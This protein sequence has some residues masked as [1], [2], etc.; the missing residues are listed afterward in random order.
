MNGI[1]L[2]NEM[3][4]RS[5]A[6][7]RERAK[8][9]IMA[10]EVLV[11]GKKA[12][13]AGTEIKPEDE[14]TVLKNPVPFVSRGGLKLDKA[15]KVFSLSLSDKRCIDVGAST[16][17]FTDCMLQNGAKHVHAV[18]VGYGQLDWK[19]RNHPDVTVMERT[20]ARY[21][22]PEWYPYLFDF[23][24]IDVSFISLKLIL[25]A[26][27]SCLNDEAEVIALIKPQFEA[28]RSEIGKKG[29]V[30]DSTVHKR[31]CVMLMEAAATFGYT[32]KGLSFSPIT[33][34]EGNIEFL[35]YL[36]KRAPDNA[37]L[38]EEFSAL[39]ESVVKAAHENKF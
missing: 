12:D 20:N 36:T 39:A 26:L 14:I 18:D 4:T 8:A 7:S 3:V 23:A 5:L 33:G 22:V 38:P 10:G 35:L 37:V 2:D 9:M 31:V 19:L 29:V 32:V 13:K 21:M 1:R 17:G 24:S 28:E 34:P 16:G 6:P 11:N 25:P 30:R 27:I 15:V